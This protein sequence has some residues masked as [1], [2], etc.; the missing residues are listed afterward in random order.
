M[1]DHPLCSTFLVNLFMMTDN[2]FL[3]CLVKMCFLPSSWFLLHTL[4]YRHTLSTLSLFSA[5]MCLTF[6]PFD[7]SVR[8]RSRNVI[9]TCKQKHVIHI[10]PIRSRIKG[11][12]LATYPPCDLSASLSLFLWLCLV[13]VKSR[14][15]F[16]NYDH[17]VE[18][19]GHEWRRERRVIWTRHGERRQLLNL[20]VGEARAFRRSQRGGRGSASDR[21]GDGRRG[22]DAE[23]DRPHCDHHGT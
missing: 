13:T 23:R 7:L 5:A 11:G 17:I 21:S 1:C 3:C 22:C 18:A 20:A 4:Q 14:S 10:Q 2:R 16:R 19:K 8:P 9:F 6:W 12:P 15:S